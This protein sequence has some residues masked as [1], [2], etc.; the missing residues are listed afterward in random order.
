MK[1]NDLTRI[2]LMTAVLC[3]LA[4]ISLPLPVS[5]VA[6]TLATFAL[7]LMAYILKPK[8]AVI[9]VGLYL[10]LGVAGLPIFSGYM[11]GISRFAAP[12]GGYLL[13]YLFLAGIGGW[14]VHRFS[15]L[16]LQIFGM[17]LG[18]F[19]MYLLGTAWMA[20]VT[21]ISFPAALPA[22]MLVFLPLDMLKIILASY[23]GRKI[24]M[25]IKK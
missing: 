16:P 3:I 17:F 19:V 14:F 15:A 20:Y 24:K 9:A 25:Y 22:G 13:G 5:S 2:A 10:L 23:I 11:A 8:Q 12:G 4:P 6:L 1:T 18:T 7:Y 21:G